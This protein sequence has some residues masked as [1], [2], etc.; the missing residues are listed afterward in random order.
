[1]KSRVVWKFLIAVRSITVVEAPTLGLV[2]LAGLDPETGGPAIW[3][4]MDPDAPRVERRF[5]IVT[6]GQRIDGDRAFPN[7]IHVGSMI[8]RGYVWHVYERRA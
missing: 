3:I 5:L 1:M 2:V 8:D 7:D 4:E 6:T